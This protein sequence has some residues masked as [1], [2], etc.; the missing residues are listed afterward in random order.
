MISFEWGLGQI[1]NIK[2]QPDKRHSW[3]APRLR[4]TQRRPPPYQLTVKAPWI[5]LLVWKKRCRTWLILSKSCVNGNKTS[6]A[7]I[8]RVIRLFLSKFNS[9]WK[10]WSS[11]STKANISRREL[12]FRGSML[13]KSSREWIVNQITRAAIG[14]WMSRAEE[15][16]TKDPYKVRCFSRSESLK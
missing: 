16:I 8:L 5:K 9:R 3:K 2:Q 13:M 14:K 4:L 1:Q 6:R 12:N 15:L 7:V 10:E 11:Q